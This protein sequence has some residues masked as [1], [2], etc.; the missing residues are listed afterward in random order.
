LIADNK[1]VPNTEQMDVLKS[2]LNSFFLMNIFESAY[3]KDNS[4][5]SV[6]KLADRINAISSSLGYSTYAS[7]DLTSIKNAVLALKGQIEKDWYI[8]PSYILQMEKVANW[9]DE[10]SNPSKPDRESLK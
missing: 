7:S 8:S 3:N 4:S 10:L 5:Q 1:I 9:C 6:S 2:N